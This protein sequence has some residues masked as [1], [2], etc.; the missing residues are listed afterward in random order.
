MSKVSVR[1]KVFSIL[2]VLILFH[3]F[4]ITTGFSGEND[5]GWT[6]ELHMKYLRISNTVISPDGK[7]IAYV[8]RK[9]V[10]EEEKSEYLS[11]IW[12]VSSDGKKNVQYTYGDK[13]CSN[14]QFSP[15]GEYL[16]F[17]S[18][19]SGKN[20]IWIM[21]VSG[22]EAKKLTDAESGIN[23]YQWSPR[24]DRIAYV[25]SNP[26]TE[27]EKS[28]E[29]G[30][31]DVILVDKDFKYNHL[32]IAFLKEGEIDTVKRLTRG[33]FSVSSF[34]W[35]PNGKTLVFS[36]Q[37]DPRLNTRFLEMD[38][39]TVPADSGAVT[40][41]INRPG[42]DAD[43]LYSPDGKW[44][45]FISN[46]G[47]PEPIGL[48]D[49]Y[50]ISSRGGRPEKLA[51]TYDRNASLIEWS[52]DSR[53]IYYS[54]FITTSREVRGLPRNGNQSFSVISETGVCSSPSINPEEKLIS[55]VY[56]NLTTPAEVYISSLNK[57]KMK[58]LTSIHQ[59]VPQPEM[60]KTELIQWNS[61][62]D[63]KVIE[64]LLT[65][66]VGYKKGDRCPLILQIHG[67]PAGVFTQAFTGDPGIYMVQYF[68]QNGYAILRPNPR[69]S[70]GYGVEF[71]YANFQDWGYGDYED[72]MSGVDKVI[73]MGVGHPDSLCVMGW[74][75]GGYMTSWI[76]TQTDRFQA[77]SMGAGLPNLISMVTTTDIQDYLAAHMGGEFWNNYKE[78][79]RH[80]AI[81][82]IKNVTTPTQV[83]HGQEDLRVP[84]TQG[85]EFYRALN[86]LG[87]E[88]EMVVYPRTPHG[89]REPKFL[90][91]VSP[92]I[93][94]W[95]DKY[96]NREKQEK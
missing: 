81:Y 38:I 4:L 77:A 3:A 55:Y 72:L 24:G 22:G 74:S 43:P 92:R 20:Q 46:G 39:S 90:M 18:S 45:A 78:Y 14:P 35:S 67:G 83:I 52:E 23:S 57:F 36:H 5:K 94:D 66:P 8:V 25:M 53:V 19:R 56:E 49:V 10:M 16:T 96:L 59:D 62:A 28:R 80:S 21:R 60:G 86:R 58:K 31:A 47:K 26:K 33:E 93:R 48:R 13:S 7:W 12:L 44:I 15:S 70:T 17:T 82:Y 40:P 50:V 34:N 76:V 37:P 54:E 73:E 87:V 30:K 91:D 63:G 95:F 79:E 64:G 89:P 11:H 69:G 85:Q 88:T 2:L 42:V 1:Q 41:L 27:E 6:P 32:Y 9:P 68:A 61:K 71:R 29:K 75:Y 51:V 84:F 65:Y